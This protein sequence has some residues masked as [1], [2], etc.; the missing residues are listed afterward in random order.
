MP[1]PF[2]FVLPSSRAVLLLLPLL[3]LL[4]LLL[5]VSP[6]LFA[7]VLALVL[8]L[9]LPS[10]MLLLLLMLLLMLPPLVGV[11]ATAAA[12]SGW[13]LRFE[14]TPGTWPIHQT[15]LSAALKVR[16]NHTSTSCTQ[17][18]TSHTLND[19]AAPTPASPPLVCLPT[20]ATRAMRPR[21]SLATATAK[22]SETADALVRDSSK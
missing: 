21:T 19:R 17:V 12:I 9:S 16:L 10:S 1:L 18:S 14:E 4:L 15:G 20:R 11:I 6:L 3:L 13:L 7:L 2:P 5:V 8:A 22:A